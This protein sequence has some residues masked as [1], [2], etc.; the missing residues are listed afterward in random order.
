MLKYKPVGLFS[1]ITVKVFDSKGSEATFHTPKFQ[2]MPGDYHLIISTDNNG[3]QQADT[4]I[5]FHA[6]TKVQVE[7]PSDLD[8]A[9]AQP[10]PTKT[11]RFWQVLEVVAN[12]KT[13][14][15]PDLDAKAVK[16]ENSLILPQKK[17][18]P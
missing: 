16:T 11:K 13:L 9:E 6:K 10:Q 2:L 4:N 5:A 8:R 7:L 17:L 1:T 15:T 18:L 12:N 3:A 14:K